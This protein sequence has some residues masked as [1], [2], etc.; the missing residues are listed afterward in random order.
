MSDRNTR[1]RRRDFLK[2]TSAATAAGLLAVPLASAQEGGGGQ[3]VKPPP[4]KI[5]EG[6]LTQELLNTIR[7]TPEV[8]LDPFPA[9]AQRQAC[10][11]GRS[12]ARIHW[13]GRWR[14][15]GGSLR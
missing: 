3:V 6:K 14:K 13:R 9:Y 7:I 5:P 12:F 11:S 15:H 8:I 10:G 4:L 2:T 1:L